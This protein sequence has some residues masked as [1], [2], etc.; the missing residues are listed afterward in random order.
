M[1]KRLLLIISCNFTKDELVDL[2]ETDDGLRFCAELPNPSG[3][4]TIKFGGK[5]GA[6]T[7]GAIFQWKKTE[8][9]STQ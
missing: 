3:T 5:I 1:Q 4:G 6:T 8:E 2:L 9:D 7:T